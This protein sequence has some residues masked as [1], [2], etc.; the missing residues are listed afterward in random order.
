[1]EDADGVAAAAHAGDHGIGQAAFRFQNL[2]ARLFADDL[3][4]IAHHH[5][6][7]MRAQR[8]SRAGNAYR[9]TL[10]TQSRMASLMASFSVRLPLVTPTHFGA[11]HAHAEDVEP[12]PAHVLLAHVDH[13]LE[14]EQRADRGR[15]DAVLARAG[16]RDDAPLAHAP[17]EQRLSQAVVD[18]VRAGVQQVF[19]LEPDAR[20]AQR[21]AQALGEIERRRAAGIVAQQVAQVRPETPDR[22][23]PRDTPSPVPRSA[24]SALRG[25]SARRR[26]RN[27]RPGRVCES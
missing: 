16:L 14:A 23:A 11:E 15:G 24:P 4:K 5:R 25:R 18:L 26:V 12:L 27:V 10:V 19:A 1:M 6:V 20:A 3:V 21:F 17:G 13:A 9:A 8:A 22:R 7:G 2:P